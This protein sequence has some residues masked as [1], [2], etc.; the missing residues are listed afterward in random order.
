MSPPYHAKVVSL[1]LIVIKK[2][3]HFATKKYFYFRETSQKIKF[4]ENENL[5]FKLSSRLLRL[6]R[7]KVAICYALLYGYDNF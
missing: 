3:G 7:E 4:V 6:L 5:M 1:V 2:S